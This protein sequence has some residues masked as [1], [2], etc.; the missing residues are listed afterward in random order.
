LGS[1]WFYYLTLLAQLALLG[2]AALSNRLGDA[3]A[4]RVARYYVLTQAAIVL[5]LWDRLRHGSGGR[6][7]KAPGTR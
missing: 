7:E 3:A 1:G 6:W 2:V 4:V 5:G